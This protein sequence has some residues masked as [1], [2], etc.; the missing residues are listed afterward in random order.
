MRQSLF[1]FHMVA[2]TALVAPAALILLEVDRSGL[3]PPEQRTACLVLLGA[4]ALA[5][6][7]AGAG[8]SLKR[9]TAFR[10]LTAL[11]GLSLALIGA[12]VALALGAGV[13]NGR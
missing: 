7:A 8:L 2:L 13:V 10:G 11:A 5:C 3:L 1:A 12:A 6:A 4:G 9:A